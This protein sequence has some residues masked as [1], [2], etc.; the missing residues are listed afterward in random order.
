M[1]PGI[2]LADGGH[3]DTKDLLVGNAGRHFLKIDI[4]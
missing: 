4:L 1:G 2:A 3:P